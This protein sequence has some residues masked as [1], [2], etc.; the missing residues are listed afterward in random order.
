M[1]F[2]LFFFLYYMFY[3]LVLLY[4]SLTRGLSLR[5]YVHEGRVDNVFSSFFTL[6]S[7]YKTTFMGL[8]AAFMS[9]HAT[10][11]IVIAGEGRVYCKPRFEFF[12]S[13]GKTESI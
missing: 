3:I 13:S 5:L 10:F 6:W 8:E 2:M 11:T 12:Y 9:P 7:I 4:M 1:S